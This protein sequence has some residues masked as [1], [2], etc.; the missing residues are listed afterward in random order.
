[1]GSTGRLLVGF[2]VVLGL[3]SP[4][5][6]DV[7]PAGSSVETTESSSFW[8][9]SY[10]R[11]G[12]MSSRTGTKN[13]LRTLKTSGTDDSG[14]LSESNPIPNLNYVSAMGIGAFSERHKVFFLGLQS[15]DSAV[16]R[17]IPMPSGK[18]F[19]IPGQILGLRYVYSMSP[20][21]HVSAG[22]KYVDVFGIGDPSLGVSYRGAINPKLFQKLG[23][24]LTVPVTS[25]SQRDALITKATARGLLIYNQS[26]WSLVGKL[27]YTRSI[28]GVASGGVGSAP[29]RSVGPGTAPKLIM[30]PVDLV[31]SEKE[32]ARLS[33]G[34][35]TNYVVAPWLK[36]GAAASI[37][38]SAT[39]STPSIWLST[40]RPVGITV[41]YKNVELAS[42]L[43][44]V[45]DIRD[46]ASLSM[47]KLWMADLKMSFALGQA[48]RDM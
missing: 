46:F 2:G 17:S 4:A 41:N 32:I 35:G 15:L 36:L 12:Y 29:A 31:L 8:K 18:S 7:L 22:A 13:D 19:L 23:L 33:A 24:D 47:P 28:F 5:L 9:N 20:S 45:S 27:A 1:M 44:F 48:P 3:A 39:P 21:V 26:A 37:T 11:M 34:L 16:E 25:K 38:H 42:N 30:E 10:L 40:I 6:G 43:S 14:S